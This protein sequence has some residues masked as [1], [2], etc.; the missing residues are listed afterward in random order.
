MSVSAVVAEARRRVS[1][2]GRAAN[3]VHRV[4]PT[5]CL[6]VDR[7]TAVAHTDGLPADQR[8]DCQR[9]LPGGPSG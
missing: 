6:N 5:P 8:H 3:A 1:P 7:S 4:V 9:R 2:H